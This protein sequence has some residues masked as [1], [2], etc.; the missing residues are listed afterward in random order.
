LGSTHILGGGGSAGS[1]V[2]RMERSEEAERRTSGITTRSFAP[3]DDAAPDG[4]S[5][6]AG[7]RFG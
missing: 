4:E 5:D 3:L 6:S 1:G 2:E 7:E